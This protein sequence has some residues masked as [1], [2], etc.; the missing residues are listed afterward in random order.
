M[1]DLKR[2]INQQNNILMSM[3]SNQR[4]IIDQLSAFA[5]ATSHS[6]EKF[7]MVDDE[8]LLKY[9]EVENESK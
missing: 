7:E 3:H 9:V 1:D 5:K 8:E 4:I 6:E 2:L